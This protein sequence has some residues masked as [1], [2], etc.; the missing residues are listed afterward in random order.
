[1]AGQRKSD[2]ALFDAAAARQDFPVFVQEINGHPLTYLDSAA[3]AQKPQAVMDA[4]TEMM[5]CYYANIHRG[6]YRF[7][8][9]TT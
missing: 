7:S 2:V 5:S 4:M 6:L 1:M 9:Q 8:Q 3:S